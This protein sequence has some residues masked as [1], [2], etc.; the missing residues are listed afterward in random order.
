MPHDTVITLRHVRRE[1]DILCL[2]FFL[3]RELNHT[4]H[5]S[6]YSASACVPAFYLRNILDSAISRLTITTPRA[7]RSF[8]FSP[9]GLVALRI[10]FRSDCLS[11]GGTRILSARSTR[12][13]NREKR[14]RTKQ[15]FNSSRSKC[16]KFN[17]RLVQDSRDRYPRNGYTLDTTLAK[18]L[19][20]F[21]S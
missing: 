4:A 12:R 14:S 1:R 2:P 16:P 10:R 5:I 13:N 11:I 15:G 9:F 20:R 21:V 17:P 6:A 7:R 19:A 8:S 3:H 18:L